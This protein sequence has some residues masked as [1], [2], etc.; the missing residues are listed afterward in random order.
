ML[1]VLP[2]LHVHVTGFFVYAVNSTF[3]FSYR[4]IILVTVEHDRARPLSGAR[5]NLSAIL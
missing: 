4:G 3:E 5:V 1:N 2:L